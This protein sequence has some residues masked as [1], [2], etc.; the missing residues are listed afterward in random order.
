MRPPRAPGNARTAIPGFVE[1]QPGDAHERGARGPQ[2][3][4]FTARMRMRADPPQGDGPTR[5]AEGDVSPP[6]SRSD[7]D[8]QEPARAGLARGWL[9]RLADHPAGALALG[10]LALLE[11]TVFPA[12]TEALLVALALARPRRA[13]WLGALAT[14]ASVVG[15]VIGYHIGAAFFDE[16]ARPILSEYGLLAQLDALGEVYRGGALLALATSGYTPIP[17]MLYTAAA[18][19]FNVP[20][21]VFITGSLVGRALKYVPLAALA[22]FLGPAVHRVMG[23]Y[24]PWVTA[25]AVVLTAGWLLLR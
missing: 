11:A 17:Y 22:Y 8:R 1:V 2:P 3:R 20:L 23:R 14:G 16:V 24:L 10:M 9:L 5:D 7:P 13:W 19:S 12:P 21:P 18:G 15:G 6:A 4:D 25:V